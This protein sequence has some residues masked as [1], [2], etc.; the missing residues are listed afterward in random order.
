MTGNSRRKKQACNEAAFTLVELLVVIAIIGI[1]VALLLPAVQAAREAARRNQCVNNIKQIS[2][3]AHNYHDIHGELMPGTRSCCW[4]SWQYYI[5]PYMEESLIGDLVHTEDPYMY[6][7]ASDYNSGSEDMDRVIQSRFASL[8]CPS[9]EPQLLADFRSMTQHNY[10]GNFGNTNH[11]GLSIPGFAGKP[12]INFLGAPLP[13][14]EWPATNVAPDKT[15]TV[16][17]AKITDGLSKTLL[18]SEAIQGITDG[19][20]HDLRGATWW[21]WAAG[22]ETSLLPNDSSPDRLQQSA[23]C[24]NNNPANP[25]CIAHSIPFNVMRHAARS[26]HPGGVNASMC[27]GSVH[28]VTNDVDSVAWSAAGSTQGGET[29]SLY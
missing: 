9:D 17:F 12:T 8:T 3:A 15:K 28:F 26:Q 19:S 24:N 14:T 20:Q 25:P 22:F 27:D 1:L 7:S 6:G 23:Y 16:P 11:Y 18:F 4:G 5:L 21:G 10:V 2:L 29:E 13:G